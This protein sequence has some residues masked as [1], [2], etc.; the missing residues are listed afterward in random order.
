MTSLERFKTILQLEEPDRV[1]WTP[2]FL[3]ASRRIYGAPHDQWSQY[4]D[5]AA[6]SIIESQN[7]FGF[8]VM[9]AGFDAFTESAGFGQE[10]SFLEDDPPCPAADSR[11]IQTPEDFERLTPYDPTQFGTRTGELIE[12]CKML[13]EEK[14]ET[15]PVI[16]IVNGPLRVLAE[17]RSKEKLLSDCETNMA[18]VLNGLDIVSNTLADYIKALAETGA[19]VMF[20]MSFASRDSLSS[21]LWLETEGR[22]MPQLSETVRASGAVVAIHSGVP[23][24]YLDTVAEAMN[25]QLF[26][27]AFLPDG[28]DDWPDLKRK[29]GD[30]MALCG[31]VSTGAL[32][33][34]NTEEVK[35]ECR[36]FIQDMAAGGGYVLSPGS[37]YPHQAN[38]HGARA[39]KEAAGLYGKY[40]L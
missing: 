29:W 21:E 1:P 31:A 24:T 15:V 19:S 39:M 4:G 14:G 34:G 6:R 3:G 22:F 35:E 8:D 20:D 16:A 5:I 28:C 9:L 30:R 36:R 40:P 17:L 32:S 33:S 10:I 26:S 18:A 12:C 37:A 23:G 25:P 7:F 11:V 13:M 38:L 27:F 2:F